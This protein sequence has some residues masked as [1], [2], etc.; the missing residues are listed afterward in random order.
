[1]S[2]DAHILE[3]PDIW[4]NWLPARYQDK[5]PQLAK[6]ADGGDAWLFAS[7]AEADPIGLTATPGMPWD[8]FRWT[9][10]TY[11]EARDGCYRGAARLDDMDA[12]GVHAEVLFPPQR[13]IGHFLGDDDD[14]FVRAG[15][16]AYNAFLWEEFCAPDRNRLIGVAQIPSTGIDD[17]VDAVRKAKATGFR[18]VVISMWPSGKDSISEDDDAFW[19]AAADEAMPVCIHINMISRRAMPRPADLGQARRTPALRQQLGPGGCQGRRQAVGRVLDGALD[20]RPAHLHRRVRALPR[21]ARRHDRDRHRLDPHFLEQMDDR[22]W[23]ATARGRTCRSRG[24]RRITGS[25]TCRRASCDDVGIRLRHEVDVASMM[26]STDYPHHGND[27]PRCARRS[28]RP[29]PVPADERGRHRLR[30]RRTIFGLGDP[31]KAG[32]LPSARKTMDRTT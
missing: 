29:W 17:A 1:M 6:D 8:Q 15:V 27:W 31:R 28:T 3:P 25:R 26:W 32:R 19:A 11:D 24:R 7:A 22:F 23:R 2:A 4:A 16:D 10:V 12:D 18:S 20:D 30:Q 9:G 13:T 14:D 5:A 21:S